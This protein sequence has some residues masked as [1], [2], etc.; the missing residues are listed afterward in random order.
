MVTISTMLPVPEAT[1]TV[2]AGK[3]KSH[4][5]SQMSREMIYDEMLQRYRTAL[6][7]CAML[8]T[9]EVRMVALLCETYWDRIYLLNNMYKFIEI[10]VRN[11][12]TYFPEPLTQSYYDTFTATCLR[13]DSARIRPQFLDEWNAHLIRNARDP[14]EV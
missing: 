10:F 8:Y 13:D 4:T 5:A 2:D 1:V 12:P 7:M 14:E 9:E 6:A 3:K 11:H